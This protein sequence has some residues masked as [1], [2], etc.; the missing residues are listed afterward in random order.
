M[1]AFST[2]KEDRALLLEMAS[3]LTDDVKAAI[4]GTISYE[5]GI[6]TQGRFTP[7]L[8]EPGKGGLVNNTITN[9]GAKEIAINVDLGGAGMPTREEMIT[10]ITNE[11][12][13]ALLADEEFL[14]I[15]GKKLPSKLQGGK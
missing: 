11:A 5:Q 1:F 12:G 9:I 13:K 3:K 10:L 14:N 8:N 15:L 6:Y 4:A 2:S 7:S